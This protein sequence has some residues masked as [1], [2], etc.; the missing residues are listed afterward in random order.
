MAHLRPSSVWHYLFSRAPDELSS[1]HVVRTFHL[2]RET[3]PLLAC[4]T[5]FPIRGW[6]RGLEREKG[7]RTPAFVS[8]AVP[9]GTFF[10]HTSVRL[11]FLQECRCVLRGFESA[12]RFCSVS[13]T[14]HVD[15]PCRAEELIL[16]CCVRAAALSRCCFEQRCFLSR[17]ESKAFSRVGRGKKKFVPFVKR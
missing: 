3:F 6:C 1:P 7:G 11:S 14:Y 9:P 8:T 16:L 5:L 10:F 17:F 13:C 2:S 12:L 15:A 4:P